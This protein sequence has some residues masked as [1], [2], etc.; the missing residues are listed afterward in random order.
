MAG[1]ILAYYSIQCI[2]ACNPALAQQQ[3]AAA[4]MYKVLDQGLCL[5]VQLVHGQLLHRR[6]AGPC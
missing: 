4:H 3:R 2:K 5:L 6:H 1:C